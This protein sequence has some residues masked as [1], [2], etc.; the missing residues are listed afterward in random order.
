MDNVAPEAVRTAKGKGSAGERI[1]DCKDISS[2]S[3]SVA[4]AAR[5]TSPKTSDNAPMALATIA[6]YKINWLNSPPLISPANTARAPNHKTNTIVP[7]TNTIAIIV[8]V[9]RARMRCIAVSKADSTDPLKRF[10]SIPSCVKAC[11]VDIAFK[12]SPAMADASAIRSCESRDN[13]RTRR[14]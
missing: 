9:E 8:N 1:L 11:T 4:P 13:A 14:P 3:R 7:N 6:A 2:K 12:I 10:A 5:C